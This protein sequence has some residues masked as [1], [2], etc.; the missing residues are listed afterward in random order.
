MTTRPA[1]AAAVVAAFVGVVALLAFVAIPEPSRE[2]LLVL[3]GILGKS[4]SDVVSF[5]FG[6]SEG[7][8]RKQDT[9]DR[10]AT[11]PATVHASHADVTGSPVTVDSDEGEPHGADPRGL[12]RP[13]PRI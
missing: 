10:L 9:L 3:V 7:S 5:H 13:V 11:Q 4:F 2:P 12:D 6:S 8:A 1:L